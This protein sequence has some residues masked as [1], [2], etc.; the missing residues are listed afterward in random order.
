MKTFK[1]KIVIGDWLHKEHGKFFTYNF[2][3]SFNQEELKKIYENAKDK[4]GFSL[5]EEFNSKNELEPEKLKSLAN[6]VQSVLEKYEEY[7]FLDLNCAKWYDCKLIDS[8][9]ALM[10][11]SK[12]ELGMEGYF[13]QEEIDHYL[14]NC[15][16]FGE[17]QNIAYN[18]LK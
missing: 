3:S 13:K 7:E 15:L 17:T 11:K 14:L 16:L 5:L 6:Y 8:F 4:I 9:V 12:E 10:H 18:F 2:V 1:Y